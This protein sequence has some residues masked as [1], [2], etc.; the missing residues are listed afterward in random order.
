MERTMGS[1]RTAIIFGV[2]GIAGRAIAERLLAM[3]GWRVL[4]VSRRPSQDLPAVEHIA[5]DI[6]DSA[7]TRDALRDVRAEH[8]YFTTWIRNATESENCR[9][10]GLMIENAL[11]GA[12]VSGTLRHA[13]L[14]TGLKHYLGS[15]ENYAQTEIDTPFS[16]DMP[17]LPGENFYYTQEDVLFAAAARHGFTWS[18]ARPHTVIGYAPGN[19]MNLGTALAVYATLARETGLPFVFPGSPQQYNGLVDMTDARLLAEHMIWE[20]NSPRAANTAF[21]VVNGDVFRWRKMWGR[22]ASYFDIP[23]APYPGKAS[24]LA[25]ML[26]DVGPAWDEIVRRRGLKTNP[27]EAVAPWWHV[28]LDFGREQET[29]A[30]MSLSRERGFLTYQRTAD[31]FTAL[32]DR[33]R[34]ERI[35]P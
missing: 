4:G 1:D 12:A 10:N 27:V 18:V 30:D 14:M 23:A 5:V 33:L 3:G 24:P 15:F 32:F 11:A 6:L 19:V 34:A 20:A 31:S 2:T 26:K 9:V 7:A 21:N 13:A 17:R 28:D 22:I 35:I 25:V 16:E 29:I 8:L